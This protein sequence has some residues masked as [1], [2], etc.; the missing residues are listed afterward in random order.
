M[1]REEA[2]RIA[3]S[4]TAQVPGV[5]ASLHFAHEDA[6]WLVKVCNARDEHICTIRTPLRP[7]AAPQPTFAEPTFAETRQHEPP[8]RPSGPDRRR[9]ERR[10]AFVVMNRYHEA[11]VGL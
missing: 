11:C 1:T 9:M 10:R 4:I 5:G 6:T 8:P 7:L 2:E 3:A